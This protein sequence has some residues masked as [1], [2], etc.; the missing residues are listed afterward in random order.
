MDLPVKTIALRGSFYTIGAQLVR[1]IFSFLSTVV[2]SRLLTPDDFGL[3]ACLTPVIAFIM[4]FQDLGLQQAVIQRHEMTED[5]LNRVFG[6]C[7]VW[8]WF[9]LPCCPWQA[10][11]RLVFQRYTLAS[12]DVCCLRSFASHKYGFFADQFNVAPDEV[13][14][15]CP[16]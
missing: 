10:S 3:V 16:D 5:Q 4:L 15:H 8:G 7:S 12:F 9:V 1:L 13:Y 11:H 14:A 2:L 6:F